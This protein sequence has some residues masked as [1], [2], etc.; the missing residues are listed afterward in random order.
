MSRIKQEIVNELHK[1]ARKNFPR[2]KTQIRGYGDLWQIDLI[3]MQ[4]Y[5]DL[6]KGYRYI[7]VVID[8]YSK[9]VWTSPLKNKTGVEVTSKMKSILN[10][11]KYT[12]KNIQSDHGTE[13]YNR[14]FTNLMKDKHI[15]HYSAYSTKKAAIVERVIKTLKHWL[16]KEFSTRGEFK[17][18]DILKSITD[19][20]NNKIHS[21]TGMKP[22]AITPDTKL[23][24][25]SYQNGG[26]TTKH[27]FNIGDI[28]RIS[29]YKGTFSKGYL[30]SWSTELFKVKR[31]K[32]TNPITYLLEDMDG[33]PIK[34]G[35]YEFELQKTKFPDTY[36]VEKILK[37]KGDKVFVKWLNFKKKFN[38]WIK[39]DTII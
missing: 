34:G 33:D 29:K 20:Y 36:L 28:V 6:N 25:F 19:R 17:W 8:C 1:A 23:S 12:P 30:I 15:N 21:T 13:F 7:L 3:E 11:A 32:H 4:P 22:S 14:H 35:F 27:K 18:T 2:R 24:M 9:Y 39:K 16:Y 31:V 38:S 37:T 5:A 26:A 10:E